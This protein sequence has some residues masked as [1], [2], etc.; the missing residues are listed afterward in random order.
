MKLC[1]SI[2]CYKDSKFL[3]FQLYEKSQTLL[4]YPVCLQYKLKIIFK[5]Y[6]K[7]LRQKKKEQNI[8]S[9]LLSQCARRKIHMPKQQ[10]AEQDAPCYTQYEMK[11]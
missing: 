4:L 3:L 2:L 8:C 1:I 9:F 10:K 6:C 7:A 5:K 11:G